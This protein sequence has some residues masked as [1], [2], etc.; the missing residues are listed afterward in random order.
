MNR[1]TLL[2]SA[3]L[4][5]CASLSPSATAAL[6]FDVS[7]TA[8]IQYDWAQVDPDRIAA[9]GE[10]G[11]RRA[12]LGF[13]LKDPGKRWQFVAEHDFADRTPA[14]AYLEL[15]PRAGH[16]IRVGQFKQP[17][18]LEDAN[19]DK[20]APF[21]EP[22]FV[23]AFAV[24]R[25]IGAEYARSGTH[26]TLNVAVFDQRLDGTS[27]SPGA[28]LRGTWRLHA[29]DTG[30]A[31]VGMS[32]SSESP[33][34]R[35]ASFSANPG[36]TLTALK[37]VSTGALAEV[38][39]LDRIALEGVWVRRNWALQ[40]EAAQVVARRDAG[41]ADFHG[42]ASSVLLTWSPAGAARTYKRGIAVAP[43]ADEAMA[44]EL[45]L[46]WSA[47]DLDD[48]AVAGGHAESI[49]LSATCY[50]TSNVRLVANVI[51]VDSAR[52]GLHDDPL[53]VGTRIQFTY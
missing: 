35:R 36:T 49:G 51:R 33:R 20:Q 10:E 25:R 44:W 7:P 46:R 45:A 39:R 48:D 50:F 3:C 14:D 31:H 15:T 47:I 9:E 18:T 5:A 6:P 37:P 23:G 12:R 26:G 19:S 41:M 53:V 22:S 40:G 11:F 30:A 43:S 24:S 4:V 29:G 13:R 21:L 52:R 1:F 42:N 34:T 2:R 28:S 17:F 27:E 8:N 32:L 38:D 16:A